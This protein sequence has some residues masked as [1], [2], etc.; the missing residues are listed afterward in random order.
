MAV[1]AAASRSNE[2][3]LLHNNADISKTYTSRKLQSTEQ[4]VAYSP[5]SIFT[6]TSQDKLNRRSEQ[7]NL[8]KSSRRFNTQ[9]LKIYFKYIDNYADNPHQLQKLDRQAGRSTQRA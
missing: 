1:T 9:E 4:A 3:S 7:S 5:R 6:D 8:I 2:S